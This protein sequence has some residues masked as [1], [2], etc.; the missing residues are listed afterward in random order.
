MS[1]RD[2]PDWDPEPEMDFEVCRACRHGQFGCTCGYRASA[3]MPSAPRERVDWESVRRENETTRR[4]AYAYVNVM[5]PYLFWAR[6][7]RVAAGTSELDAR[8]ATLRI[9]ETLLRPI[10]LKSA[11]DAAQE[12]EEEF[13]NARLDY[14][15]AF[16]NT[17]QPN[18]A[19][20]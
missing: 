3:S 7:Y 11:Q 19:K 15:R 20:E 13:A 2:V 14:W 9:R 5:C 6:G 12:A 10:A 18:R 16:L 1:F 8:M 17:N 4:A